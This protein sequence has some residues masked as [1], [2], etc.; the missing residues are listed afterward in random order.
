MSEFGQ[1]VPRGA[2]NASKLIAIVEDPEN[3]LP[4][5]AIPTLKVLI[6]VLAHLGVEIAKLDAEIARRA[7]E[8]DVARRLM[9]V[10]PF[11]HARMPCRATGH[12]SVDS[13]GHC[14]PGPAAGDIPKSTRL[15]RMAWLG[16][17][18]T[19]DRGKTTPRCHY[20]DERTIPATLADCRVAFKSDTRRVERQFL[21]LNVIFGWLW[22]EDFPFSSGNLIDRIKQT[23][24]LLKRTK[25]SNPCMSVDANAEHRRFAQWT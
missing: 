8:N 7:K 6:A 16:A 18:A 25:Q 13:H 14:G 11:G 2:A 5:D 12:W 24:F 3:I 9:T 4:V 23:G 15:C 10:R 19:F 22:G 17:T 21:P 20:P 1:I